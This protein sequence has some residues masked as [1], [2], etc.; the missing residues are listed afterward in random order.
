[1]RVGY[2]VWAFG[3]NVVTVCRDFARSMQRCVS[4]LCRGLIH[5]ARNVRVDLR[6]SGFGPF[7]Q[8]PK[9]KT[10]PP[11]LIS[12]FV[13]GNTNGRKKMHLH[14]VPQPLP[15]FGIRGKQSSR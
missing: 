9:P 11:E 2:W 1:M 12:G 3:F 13:E 6:L 10:K 7:P 8:N 14:V 4:D 15:G 5:Q